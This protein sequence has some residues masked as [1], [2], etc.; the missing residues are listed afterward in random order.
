[1]DF[2]VKE[3]RKITQAIQVCVSIVDKKV[4]E[5]EIYALM[6]A[7]NELEAGISYY[8]YR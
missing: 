1:M 4:M 2:I 7:Q 5:R 3:G 6:E 8:T